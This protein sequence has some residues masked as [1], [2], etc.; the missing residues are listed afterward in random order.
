MFFTLFGSAHPYE[1]G[2][3]VAAPGGDNA[4]DQKGETLTLPPIGI[5]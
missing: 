3:E 1:D 4:A 2:L 5:V